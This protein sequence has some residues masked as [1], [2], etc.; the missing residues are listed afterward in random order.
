MLSKT[1]RRIN[2]VNRPGM[3]AMGLV[4]PKRAYNLSLLDRVKEK[5]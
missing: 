3:A 1:L 2:V 5:F 4:N